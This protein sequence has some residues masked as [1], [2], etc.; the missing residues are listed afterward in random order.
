MSGETLTS[1]QYIQHHLT[2]LTYGKLPA[3]FH[4]GDGTVLQD[5]T[6]T[7]AHSS[8]EA[9]A[10]GFNAINLDTMGW[11]LVLG[12]LFFLLFRMVAKNV[13]SGEPSGLQNFVEA[14]FGE[15]NMDQCWS[16]IYIYIYRKRTTNPQF[17]C[18][19]SQHL[20]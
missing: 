18:T 7:L 5:A 10:M 6:W 20:C 8:E 12:S 15:L 19:F 4:R 9:A 11:S 14:V 17:Q 3:G 16:I 13:T 2:N 1:S